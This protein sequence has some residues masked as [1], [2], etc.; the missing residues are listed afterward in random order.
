MLA[1]SDAMDWRC[2]LLDVVDGQLMGAMKGGKAV[3]ARSSCSQ[4]LTFLSP[5]SSP[6]IKGYR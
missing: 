5:Q 6:S 2:G 4:L 1:S 3:G